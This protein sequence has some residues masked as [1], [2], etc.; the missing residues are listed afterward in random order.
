MPIPVRLRVNH[1][2][3]Q[4][5]VAGQVKDARARVGA[6]LHGRRAIAGTREGGH[7]RP[8]REG[9][10]IRAEVAAEHLLGA[11][12]CERATRQYASIAV[13]DDHLH[14]REK[15]TVVPEH[16]SQEMGED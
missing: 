7:R 1:T 6:F 8:S 4:H 15:T 5:D 9:E 12:A 10:G 16:I 3:R 2:D 14:T 11:P 13:G